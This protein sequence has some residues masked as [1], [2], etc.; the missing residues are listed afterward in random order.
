MKINKVKFFFTLVLL[1]VVIGL[2]VIF[3]N[4]TLNKATHVKLSISPT[5][6]EKYVLTDPLFHDSA[7]DSLQQDEPLILD[8]LSEVEQLIEGLDDLTSNEIVVKLL[9]TDAYIEHSTEILLMLIKNG[10]LGVNESLKGNENRS[11]YY[12]PLFV[13]L[14]S[15]DEVRPEQFNEFM[16]L[17]AV[18]DTSNAWLSKLGGI[19]DK[20]SIQRWVNESGIGS[21]H[22]KKLVELGLT[23]GSPQLVSYIKES[24]PSGLTYAFPAELVA[25]RVTVVNKYVAEEFD[26]KEYQKNNQY[27]SEYKMV[28][29]AIGYGNKMLNITRALKLQSGLT[30][31]EIQE[32]DKSIAGIQ[33]KINRLQALKKTFH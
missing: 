28:L 10:T 26:V 4:T 8:Q 23:F 14:S 31:A 1:V 7:E 15:L 33:A 30:Q 17:G 5:P 32:L 19:R 22:Y 27:V 9:G 3:E 16:D 11:A 6:T 24:D 13:A 21:E 29:G 12:T 18:I 20:D 25:N 2:L